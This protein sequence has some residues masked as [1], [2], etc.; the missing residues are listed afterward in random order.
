MTDWGVGW[1]FPKKDRI[2]IGLSAKLSKN[3]NL[4]EKFQLFLK[5]LGFFEK[6]MKI[7]GQFAPFGDYKKNPGYKNILLCGD[8]AG[9]LDPVTGEGIAY[10]L[11]SGFNAA[12]SIVDCNKEQNSVL[13]NYKKRNSQIMKNL[14]YANLLKFLLFSKNGE[15]MLIDNLRTSNSIALLALDLLSDEIDYSKFFKYISKEYATNTISKLF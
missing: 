8:A 11:E 12:L 9:Y 7:E 6:D 13:P 10:A 3:E 14:D 1:S 15:K 2:T 5:E 4:R